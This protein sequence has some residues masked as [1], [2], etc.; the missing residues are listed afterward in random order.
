MNILAGRALSD[1][2]ADT[3]ASIDRYLDTFKDMGQLLAVSKFM[4][5]IYEC[6]DYLQ[7]ELKVCY[8]L[9]FL[10]INFVEM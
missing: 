2:I 1:L 7:S 5:P 6:L 8:P 10:E 3:D 9:S 4:T